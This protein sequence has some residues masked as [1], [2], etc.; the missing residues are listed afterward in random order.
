M[1]RRATQG[2]DAAELVAGAEET[3]GLCSSC[4]QQAFIRNVPSTVQLDEM[5]LRIESYHA[6]REVKQC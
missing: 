4:Q 1:I 5:L 3:P 6:L 2:G